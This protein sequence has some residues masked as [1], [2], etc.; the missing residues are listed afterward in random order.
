MI[1]GNTSQ[2]V[3][4]NI[5]RYSS[6]LSVLDPSTYFTKEFIQVMQVQQ[7][8]ALLPSFMQPGNNLDETTFF[9]ELL[10]Q[11]FLK[12]YVDSPDPAIQKRVQ[13]LEEA[14]Q[15][16][17]IL[18]Y[19]KVLSSV[20]LVG[21]HAWNSIARRSTK[22]I[23]VKFGKSARGAAD[24]ILS[25][26]ISIAI[27]QLCY[28]LIKWSDLTAL[29]QA[30]FIVG[31]FSVLTTLIRKGIEAAVAYESTGSL[32][33]AFKVFFG[34]EIE[35]YQERITSFLGRW[36]TNNV[37]RL[38]PRSP[39]DLRGL[40]FEDTGVAEDYPRFT[41]IMGNSLDEFMA[42]RF[43]AAMA[44]VGIVLSAIGL[45]DST[46]PLDKA[47]NSMFLV[48]SILDLAAAAAEWAIA[49]GVEE[50]SGLAIATISSLAGPLAIVAA[51]VGVILLLVSIFT[52][53]KPRN[54]I[55]QFVDRADVKSA[56]FYMQYEAC[57]EYFQVISDSDHKLRDIGV[58]FKPKSLAVYLVVNSDGSLSCGPLSH[59]F[60]TVLSVP[61][62]YQGQ[63]YILTQIWRRRDGGDGYIRDVV[64]LTLKDNDQ[65][66]MAGPI[67]DD[68]QKS[69]QLWIATCV[70]D[71]TYESKNHLK[72]ASFTIENVHSKGKYL[73]VSSN[74]VTVAT[75]P[76]TWTLSM[77]P[78]K[79]AHLTFHNIN[80]VTLD[81]DR[82][83]SPDLGQVGSLTTSTGQ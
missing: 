55:D 38:A 71:V 53:K 6:I 54:P 57:I 5:Q 68:T 61:T 31:C 32:W 19:M 78:M 30:S 10:I 15:K 28:G 47:M 81:R 7:L 80:L 25:V 27:V 22:A 74:A 58:A 66:S 43:A 67:S 48:S 82:K 23:V 62:D 77:E 41:R 42:T 75:S 16:H 45:A 50:I 56:G 49:A 69:K 39:E 63:S 1:D 24:T 20:S 40:F 18:E 3:T 60:D 11:K 26:A 34:K 79:P 46:T 12:K 36:V 4:Q 35:V 70:G 64:A 72:S 21:S 65:L 44:I 51:I 59:G 76:T 73:S 17:S 33:E 83:Y 14:I 2:V 13:E 29:Q 52:A 37:E 9:M 8:T